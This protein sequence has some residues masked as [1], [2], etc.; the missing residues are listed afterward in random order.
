MDQEMLHE[1]LLNSGMSTKVSEGTEEEQ[2]YVD[3]SPGVK[4][5]LRRTHETMQAI[6]MD[7]YQSVCCVS[8]SKDVL[9]IADVCYVICPN[10]RVISPVVGEYFEGR[11]VHRHGLGLGFTCESLFKMQNEIMQD[12]SK[13]EKKE[14]K[15]PAKAP[16]SE[17]TYQKL[18]PASISTSHY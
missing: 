9:C 8:C 14:T 3:I 1:K 6:A 12:R 13:Y 18:K 7:F 15:T 10:C 16:A 11:E 17:F 4:L 5:P 2:V